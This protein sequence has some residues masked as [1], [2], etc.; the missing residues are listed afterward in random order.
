ML[1]LTLNRR[2]QLT[3]PKPVR[4][5]LGVEPGDELVASVVDGAVL[6]APARGERLPLESPPTRDPQEMLH[7]LRATGRYSEESLRSL[8]EGMAESDFFGR[9]A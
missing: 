5:R 1:T 7:S 4:Q 2:N 3:L 8:A 9:N 6:L